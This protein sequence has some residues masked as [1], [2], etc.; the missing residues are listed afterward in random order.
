MDASGNTLTYTYDGDGKLQSVGNPT[1][2]QSLVFTYTNN[3]LT[4]VGDQAGRTVT[5]EYTDG[6]MTTFRD[7]EGYASV[8]GYDDAHRLTTVTTPRGYTITTNIYDDLGRVES[9]TDALGNTTT[10]YFGGYRNVEARPDGG[11]VVYYVDSRGLTTDR[12]DVLGNRMTMTYDGQ[13]RLR[14]ATDREGSTITFE[15]HPA[16]GEYAAVTNGEGHTTRYTYT[17]QQQ[18]CTNPL[19]ADTV[20]FT[21][22]YVEQVDY[23]DGNSESYTYDADGN[24]ET[25]TDQAGETW[26]YEYNERG[27]LIRLTN[28]AGGVTEYAYNLDGTQASSTDSDMG[29]TTYG[30]DSYLRQDQVTQPGGHT[31]ITTYNLNDRATMITD[32]RNNVT[33]YQYDP[34]GNLQVS[35]DALGNQTSYVFNAVDL[36]TQTT[37]RRG[38]IST[39]TYDEM[40]R[41][42]TSTDPNGSTV[43]SEY[44]P[45]GWLNQTTDPAENIWQTGR[46]QEGVVV[47][48]TTPQGIRHHLRP[49]F[50]R[51]H[52]HD[53]RS[54]R[55]HHHLRPR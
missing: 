31:T 42:E 11:R 24:M 28:P 41:L 2:G 26:T 37:D 18:T 4:T 9:Q 1:L 53:Q 34:N 39:Q 8:Y 19:N 21:S 35:T 13:H 32:A 40:N 27:Q 33:T 47:S 15:Y 17:S 50:A 52:D 30:H 44:D 7:A 10:F 55:P 12:E 48:R 25:R 43:T 45:R 22:Y 23:P 46:S 3:L 16:S 14:T 54:A 29:V 36:V 6:E 38:N 51:Q 20:T 49:R 5:F